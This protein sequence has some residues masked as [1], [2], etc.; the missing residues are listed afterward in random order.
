MKAAGFIGV[1]LVLGAAY[2]IYN[3]QPTRSPGTTA[4]PQEQID[5]MSIRTSLLEIGQ[6]ERQYVIA[7][8]SYGT[9]DQLRA[10]GPPALGTPRR[11]Y[12]FQVEPN[13][14]RGFKASATPTDPNKPGWPTLTLDDTMQI[15][16][17]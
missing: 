14:A 4:S 5:V 7:H 9:L 13:G 17:R 15:S 6:A 3:A 1:L 16:A 12:V 10:D 2:I 8:G 11:G